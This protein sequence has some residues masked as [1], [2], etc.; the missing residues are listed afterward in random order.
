MY[1]T[2]PLSLFKSHP[3][4][5]AEPPPEGRNAGYLI[6]KSVRDEE[7]DE[8]TCLDPTRRI[9]GLP[10]PQN[11]VLGVQNGKFYV[12]IMFVPVPDQ[13]LASNRYYIVAASGNCKG[14]VMACS[15]EEDMTMCCFCKCI[16]D[17]APR[18]FDPADVYQQIEI[19]QSPHKR[20]WF[21]ARSVAADGFPPSTYRSKYWKVDDCESKKKI[22]L[23]EAPGLHVVLR[24]RR[25]ADGV[26]G[27]AMAVVGKWYCPFFLIREDG[28][29]RRDQVGRFYEVVLEQRWE[30]VHG[31]AVRHVDDNSKLASKKVLVGGSAE[32][33]LEVGNSRDGTTNMWFVAATTGQRVGVCTTLW[34]RMLWEETQGGWVYEEK[35]AGSV[36]DGSVVLVERF[37]VKRMDGSVVV[38][39]DFVH[40]NTTNA[41]RVV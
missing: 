38:A 19:V 27:A 2:K 10:F 17:A 18:P 1:T 14:L 11:R 35:D 12:P 31:D 26:P 32:A 34:E 36:A 33:K 40:H 7:D 41:V 23:G 39:F 29:V 13:P 9:L 5:A 28:V 15:R 8:I 20:G 21:T 3:E 25:L 16:P 24:S 30:P 6:V 22:V 37:V 4:A